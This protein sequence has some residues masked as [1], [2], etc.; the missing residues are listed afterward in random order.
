[1]KKYHQNTRANSI[2]AMFYALIAIAITLTT[3]RY[4]FKFSRLF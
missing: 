4:F 2:G 3:S 1:M